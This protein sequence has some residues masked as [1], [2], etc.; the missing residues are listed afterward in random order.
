VAIDVVNNEATQLIVEHEMTADTVAI[1]VKYIATPLINGL[2]FQLYTLSKHHLNLNHPFS[3]IIVQQD[4]WAD[5]TDVITN[6]T[7]IIGSTAS[8]KL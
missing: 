5:I 6:D 3:A 2:K 8:L 4:L 7:S 1:D